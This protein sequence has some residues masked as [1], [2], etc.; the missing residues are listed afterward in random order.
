M[1]AMV[2]LGDLGKTR[3]PAY[4]SRVCQA[5]KCN[6]VHKLTHCNPDPI[7]QCILCMKKWYEEEAADHEQGLKN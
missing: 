1:S 5:C 3:H 7:Y 4:L 2:D 6:T